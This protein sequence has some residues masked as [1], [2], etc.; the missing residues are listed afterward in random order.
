MLCSRQPS[1]REAVLGGGLVGAVAL[2]AWPGV[3][4]SPRAHGSPTRI[5]APARLG[6]TPTGPAPSTIQ[7]ADLT[8]PDVRDA[9]AR[10]WGTAI[11]PTGGLEQNGP[12]L[13]IGKHDRVVHW[14]AMRI[15]AELGDA[16]VAPVVSYVPEGDYSPPT[17]HMGFPGTL[18]VTPAVFEGVLDGIARSLKA[19]GFD[20]VCFL[21]DHG[22]SL[23]AQDRVAERLSAEWA[24]SG[25]R[26]LGV[27][28][29]YSDVLER[30]YLLAHGESEAALGQHAGLADTAELLAV[31]PAG[32]DL[33]RLPDSSG[34][35]AEL[36]G[37]GNPRRASAAQGA[38]LMALRIEAAVRQIRDARTA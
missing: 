14:A 16:L 22:G 32:V 25:P 21:S 1:R 33:S 19:G 38:A 29:Y 24:T 36:G 13:I 8:W 10:G 27:S 34:A 12:H 4:S 23:S 6:Q 3:V 5:T 28:A 18:G 11:V 15:A 7:I 17:G 2:A 30:D 26:V 37:S 35:L 9:I 20:M 31:D